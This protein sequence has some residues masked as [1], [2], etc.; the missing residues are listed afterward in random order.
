[1]TLMSL[2]VETYLHDMDV[3]GFHSLQL[4]NNCIILN[5]CNYIDVIH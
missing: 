4:I 5:E 1:M 2:E 3:T